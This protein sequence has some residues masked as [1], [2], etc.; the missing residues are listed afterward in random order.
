MC[1]YDAILEFKC[2]YCV[3]FMEIKI[4]YNAWSYS[5]MHGNNNDIHEQLF[6]FQMAWCHISSMDM[7]FFNVLDS[8]I[9]E[10]SAWLFRGV[11]CGDVCG[12]L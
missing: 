5:Y 11:V 12:R 7:K 8:L 4:Y 9:H 6:F 10:S 1:H 2:A 3:I